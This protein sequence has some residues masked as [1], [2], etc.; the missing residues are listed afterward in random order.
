MPDA[1]PPFAEAFVVEELTA[2]SI[3]VRHR[4]EGHWWRFDVAEKNGRRQ[5]LHAEHRLGS[6]PAE[7]M[8]ALAVD[9]Y[10]AATREA[11]QRGM[12]D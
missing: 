3:A 10:D 4:I 2:D 12:V 11:R 1:I 8:T 7:F 5:L 6:A 9:A